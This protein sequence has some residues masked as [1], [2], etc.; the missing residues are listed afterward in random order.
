MDVGNKDQETKLR[1]KYK[2]IQ[3]K[4]HHF[5]TTLHSSSFPCKAVAWISNFAFVL[6]VEDCYF[7]KNINDLKNIMI[8]LLNYVTIKETLNP[9]V[10]K[11]MQIGVIC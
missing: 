7:L 4:H 11:Q 10:K 8:I 5:P 9:G 2:R 1:M 3:I 6:L